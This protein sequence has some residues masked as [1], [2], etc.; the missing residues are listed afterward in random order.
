MLTLQPSTPIG[1]ALAQ[2]AAAA[3]A[4]A[5][6]LLRGKATAYIDGDARWT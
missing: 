4:A 3:A 1:A 5:T 2:A 6:T